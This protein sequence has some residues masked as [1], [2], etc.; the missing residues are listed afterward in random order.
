MVLGYM[1]FIRVVG[2]AEID[3]R[4]RL[5]PYPGNRARGTRAVATAM[6]D[7][8][9]MAVLEGWYVEPGE[10]CSA[11]LSNWAKKDRTPCYG[12]RERGD[13]I[14]FR[15]AATARW[16]GHPSY[17]PAVPDNARSA[18]IRVRGCEWALLS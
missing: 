3:M 2:V 17:A 6:S 7:W 15:V 9:P 16:S 14:S 12:I 18:A 1:V 4:R 10:G 8:R 11:Y 5:P 13:P